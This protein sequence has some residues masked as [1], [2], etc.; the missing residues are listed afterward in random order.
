MSERGD[1]AV[2]GRQPEHQPQRF[3]VPNARAPEMPR[4]SDLV[5]IAPY[6]APKPVAGLE[7][8]LASCRRDGPVEAQ[9]GQV[10]AGDERIDDADNGVGAT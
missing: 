4:R 10:Q 5:E 8:W 1:G 2:V 6:V 3:K 7:A 9:A